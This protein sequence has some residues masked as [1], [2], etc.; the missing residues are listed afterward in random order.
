MS[1]T[2]NGMTTTEVANQILDE[3]ERGGNQRGISFAS[4]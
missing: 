3:I 1:N 4:S 2:F